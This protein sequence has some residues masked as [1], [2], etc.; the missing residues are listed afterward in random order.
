MTRAAPLGRFTLLFPLWT[1]LAAALGLPCLWVFTWLQGPLIVLALA[2]VM[3][4]MGLELADYQRVLRPPGPPA[5]GVA[6]QFLVMP[7]LAALV[8]ALLRLPPPLAVGLILV[9]CCPGGTASN[10]VTLIARADMPHS[11]VMTTLCTL[12]AVLLTGLLAGRYLT[13]DGWMCCS[14]CCCRWPWGR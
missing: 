5:L 2:L 4:G 10:V 1:L 14:W 8:A 13:V 11:V 12:A 7:A 6:A 3:L 9:G